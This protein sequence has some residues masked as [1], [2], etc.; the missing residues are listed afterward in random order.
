[1]FTT[2]KSTGTNEQ[3]NVRGKKKKNTTLI[4]LAL[5]L[6]LTLIIPCENVLVD[7]NI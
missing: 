1:L 2:I 7:R 3:Q 5:T 4:T 6:T